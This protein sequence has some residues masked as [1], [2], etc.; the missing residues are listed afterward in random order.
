VSAAGTTA[1]ATLPPVLW[2]GVRPN[3]DNQLAP[4][5]GSSQ[6]FFAAD[7]KTARLGLPE[8]PIAPGG[9]R[10]L[11]R[12]RAGQIGPECD[13]G[14]SSN[15]EF[16]HGSFS[17]KSSLRLQ[18]FLSMQSRNLDC[19]GRAASGSFFSAANALVM[20]RQLSRFPWSRV[21][22]PGTAIVQGHQP[23]PRSVSRVQTIREGGFQH[24]FNPSSSPEKPSRSTP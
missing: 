20:F 12:I 10:P 17:S 24:G 21:A 18:F 6:A 15:S 11:R 1:H 13:G 9:N 16:E 23:G 14:T 5:A 22:R 8:A 4:V 7:P 2:N 19:L 3:F